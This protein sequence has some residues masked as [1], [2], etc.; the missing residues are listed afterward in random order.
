MTKDWSK[1]RVLLMVAALAAAGTARAATYTDL[2]DFGGSDGARPVYQPVLGPHGT[3]YG[4]TYAGGPDGGGTVYKFSGG[5]LTTLLTGAQPEPAP[6][7]D[8]DGNLYLSFISGG[9]HGKGSIAR[10]D[11]VNGLTTLYSFTGGADGWY[12]NGLT[13]AADG[14]VYGTASLGGIATGYCATTGCGTIFKLSPQ[15]RLTVLHRFNVGNG[16]GPEVAPLR[17]GHT[18]FGATL[19]AATAVKG[20]DAG[21]V[22]SISDTG[23]DFKTYAMPT[24]PGV[25]YNFEGSLVQDSAGNLWGTAVENSAGY[26]AIYKIDTAGHFSVAYVF[27]AGADGAYPF[28][29]LEIDG[30]DV[31]YGT[32]HGNETYNEGAGAGGWG[33]VFAYDT[34]RGVLT[35]LHAFSQSDGANPIGGVAID[36]SGKLYGVTEFGGAHDMGVLYRIAP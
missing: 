3:L 1:T 13:L 4:T 10:W 25:S 14:T 34:K 12:P 18:L 9:A 11:P 29:D 21:S 16:A 23:A 27:Q 32:T 36:P 15:G 6:V 30:N 2:H 19:Q 8:S 5:N 17:V 20:A 24:T 7:V 22:F 31:V 28:S 26:G 35:T 33:T